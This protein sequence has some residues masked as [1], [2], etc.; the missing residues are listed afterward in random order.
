VDD[1]RE[2]VAHMISEFVRDV[3][4]L[5]L[6]FVPLDYLLKNEPAR[7]YVWF[8]YAGVV[9]VS[10]SL[11]TLGIAIERRRKPSRMVA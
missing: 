9:A 6:V 2:S 10:L 1:Y 7:A 5:I 8:G 11:L 4:V 3:A